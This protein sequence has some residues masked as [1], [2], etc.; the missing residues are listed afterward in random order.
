M[1]F[2]VLSAKSIEAARVEIA[3]AQT[4]TPQQFHDFHRRMFAERGG[5]DGA[6]A[7][8]LASRMG[9]DAK[10]LTEAANRTEV[11][12]AMKRNYR[13]GS[14]LGLTATPSFIVKD[15]AIVGYPG[16]KAMRGVVESI[17]RCD[18]PA[19]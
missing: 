9:F 15:V 6:R 5:M 13:L 12:E 18:K 2:P 17:H 14:A 1:P 8:A 19:C 3:L 16:A 4:A 10:Q 11:T 7:L